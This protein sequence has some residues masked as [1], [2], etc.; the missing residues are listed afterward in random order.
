MIKDTYIK[1]KRLIED[2]EVMNKRIQ[3]VERKGHWVTIST[4]DSQPEEEFSY[5][6]QKDLM[7]WLK[8]TKEKYQKEFDELN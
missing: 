2:I 7:N 6:F 4:I 3:E 1:A 8:Q 5:Q